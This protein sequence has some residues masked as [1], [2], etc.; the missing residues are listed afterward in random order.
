M[1]L[2]HVASPIPH[3]AYPYRKLLMIQIG[4]DSGICLQSL[5][6]LSSSI[7]LLPNLIEHPFRALSLKMRKCQE[8]ILQMER[9]KLSSK[10]FIINQEGLG[11]TQE[12]LEDKNQ[13]KTQ[14]DNV[15]TVLE[16]EMVNKVI[17]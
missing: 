11:G 12:Y 10:C 4:L 1:P 14:K 2:L 13:L 5:C 7:L 3:V 6:K 15:V 16:S 17:I 8:K 9:S